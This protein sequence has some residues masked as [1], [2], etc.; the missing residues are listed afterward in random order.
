MQILEALP[1]NVPAPSR[2]RTFVDAFLRNMLDPARPAWHALLLAREQ[3]EPSE[4]LAR[5]KSELFSSFFGR[6]QRLMAQLM[7]RPTSQRQLTLCVE[8]V[9]GQCIF[10]VTHQR[11][12]RMCQPE[13]PPAAQRLDELVDHITCFSLA[14]IT[15]CATAPEHHSRELRLSARN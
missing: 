8:S 5:V 14:G 10:H 1:E 11:M 13:L 3:L 9:M 6:L 4:T 2:L 7:P 12:Q 15:S